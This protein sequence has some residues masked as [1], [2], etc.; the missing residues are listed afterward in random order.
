M[1]ISTEE[2]EDGE[3]PQQTYGSEF[4]KAERMVPM[5][6]EHWV[7]KNCY[8]ILYD[9]KNQYYSAEAWIT[10]ANNSIH[11][12]PNQYAPGMS[13]EKGTTQNLKEGKVSAT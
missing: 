5:N 10:T 9:R 12:V 13:M 8:R 3:M 7:D 11:D 6:M 4:N 1:V 2:S